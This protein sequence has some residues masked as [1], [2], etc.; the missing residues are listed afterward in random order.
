MS[1]DPA[2]VPAVRLNDGSDIPQFGF[3]V[4]QIPPDETVTAV[5]TALDAG[6][7]HID[8]AQMYGN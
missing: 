2:A 6:Y 3:G 4:F 1:F 7:R 8:T 5:R